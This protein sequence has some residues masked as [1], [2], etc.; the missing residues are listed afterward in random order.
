MT[1]SSNNSSPQSVR[2][3]LLLHGKAPRLDY[4][5]TLLGRPAVQ[6]DRQQRLEEA[7]AAIAGGQHRLVVVEPQLLDGA[8]L[9]LA[10]RLFA[11]PDVRRP[12]ILRVGTAAEV[13]TAWPFTTLTFTTTG[14]IETFDQ[15]LI[16]LLRLPQRQAPRY[17]T[18]LSFAQKG[19]RAV[20]G[21][22]V[23]IS[24]GGMLFAS[25]QPLET[26]TRVELE[27]MGIPALREAAIRGRILRQEPAKSILPLYAI[28]FL[29]MTAD[30][31]QGL[32]NFLDSVTRGQTA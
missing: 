12:P 11:H 26:G 22:S 30:L 19:Q 13:N 16:S 9:Q 3:V 23:N 18:R 15:M 5:G 27:I 25:T 7:Y 24:A 31:R 32:Q 17:T 14:G 10:E 6:L 21:Q 29:E 20:V 2:P 4:A 1:N 8:S 28:E